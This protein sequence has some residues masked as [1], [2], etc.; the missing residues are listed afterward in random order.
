MPPWVVI[1]TG[2]HAEAC[3]RLL[4]RRHCRT[5]SACRTAGAYLGRRS[6]ARLPWAD[7]HAFVT[8]VNTLWSVG[9]SDRRSYRPSFQQSLAGIKNLGC[10]FRQVRSRSAPNTASRLTLIALPSTAGLVNPREF[11]SDLIL[12][13]SPILRS[14]RRRG[15]ERGCGRSRR[16]W[17]D[18]VPF[19]AVDEAVGGRIAAAGGRLV[20]DLGQQAPGLSA[21]PSIPGSLSNSSKSRPGRRSLGQH[22]LDGDGIEVAQHLLPGRGPAR[23]GRA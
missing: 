8:N 7:Y 4:A 22:L 2:W 6:L 9:F 23:L 11:L 19:L 17:P 5:L 13:W 14:R 18:S 3:G 16:G 21:S 10:R 12:S 1:T 20:D 15:A